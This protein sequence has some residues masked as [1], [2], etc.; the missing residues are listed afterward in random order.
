MYQTQLSRTNSYSRIRAE[1]PDPYSSFGSDSSQRPRQNGRGDSSKKPV[2]FLLKIFVAIVVST[3]TLQ[4][5][6]KV[7]P[8][9]LNQ[10]NM[11]K[12]KKGKQEDF[13]KPDLKSHK[14]EFSFIHMSFYENH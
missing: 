8:K 3:Y 1:V 2:D 10:I 4:S 9:D 7:S 13:V 6:F 5:I 14:G 12:L 11:S